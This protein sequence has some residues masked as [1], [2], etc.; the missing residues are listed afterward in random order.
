MFNNV[1]RRAASAAYKPTIRTLSTTAE[2]L[3]ARPPIIIHRDPFPDYKFGFYIGAIS[4][5]CIGITGTFAY[6][7]N[8]NLKVGSSL[9]R[10]GIFR[11]PSQALC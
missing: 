8:D 4:G 9:Y 7:I 1:I 10:Y 5:L 3:M 11:Y 2:P 6:V